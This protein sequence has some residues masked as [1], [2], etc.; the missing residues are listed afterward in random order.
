[1]G[2]AHTADQ[3]IENPGTLKVSTTLNL[4]SIL[5]VVLGAISFFVAYSA[6][7]THAWTSF[8]KA[9]F[10]FM[11]ISVMG[12]F[13][14]AIHWVTTSMWSAPIRRLAEGLTAY[15][16]V[17]LVTSM[18][19]ILGA[20]SIFEWTHLDKIKGDLVI[21][22]KLG[23][24]NMT[25]FS[26]RAIGGVLGWMWFA[27]K[28]VGSSVA[29]DSVNDH[30]ENFKKVYES[31]RKWSVAFLVFFAIS[32]SAIAFD[33][34][35]SLDPHFF[36]TMFG[37]Y[38]FAGS[39]QTFFAVIA[40]LTI[41]M[42]KCGYLKQVINTNHYHDIGKMLFAFTVFWAY[43]GFAQYMLIWYANMPEETGFF[44]LRF[45]QGWEFWSLALFVGKFFVPFFL[46]LPRANKRSESVLLIASIWV[47]ISQYFDLNWLI[48][49][50]VFPDGPHFGF[51]DIG[52]WLGFL[53]MF[54]LAYT[55]FFKKRNVLAITDP[56]LPESAFHHHVQ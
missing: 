21:E 47:I 37:V 19:V 4:V 45:N 39:F 55:R 11:Q 44:L 43:T 31:N 53:G 20:H 27:K 38:I 28:M 24:L 8:L 48:Q 2:H 41:I 30:G 18:L 56:Y 54:I 15:L 12:L 25:F 50:Q 17:A 5:L 13:F 16:P 52:I 49:P 10:F 40:V 9:H 29:A 42:R 33:Q 51:T 6:D 23:Y 22:G 1:M 3:K 32:F 14:P 35:M 46:L 26:I 34:L 7:H 36:S